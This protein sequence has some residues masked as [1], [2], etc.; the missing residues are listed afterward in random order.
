MCRPIVFFCHWSLFHL[1]PQQRWQKLFLGKISYAAHNGTLLLVQTVGSL[2]S[3]FRSEAKSTAATCCSW[4]GERGGLIRRRTN[5]TRVELSL[6][7]LVVQIKRKPPRTGPPVR[8]ICLY[9]Y[10][11]E[12]KEKPTLAR[13]E[14]NIEC[15]LR[16][17]S[18]VDCSRGIRGG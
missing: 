17:S 16:G 5:A 7:Q 18:C 4:E 8:Q 1:A 9:S 14:G 11:V 3:T 2:K 15:I 12:R 13:L 6:G 10:S